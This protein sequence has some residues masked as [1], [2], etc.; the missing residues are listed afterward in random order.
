MEDITEQFNLPKYTKGKSFAD[1]SSMIMDKF[2]ER[3][4]PESKRTMTEMLDRLRQAQEFVKEQNKTPEERQQEQ[5]QMEQQAQM[6]AKQS[7]QQVDPQM[8]QQVLQEQPQQTQFA[9]G[10]LMNYISKNKSNQ[11]D[12]GGVIS[13]GNKFG[14]FMKG[15]AGGIASAGAGAMNMIGDLSGEGVSTNAGTAGLT[16]AAK[17]AMAGMAL[18]PVG[19][20]IGGVL[21]G[22]AGLIGS[23][24]AK[25]EMI[26]NERNE[27]QLNRN[28][29]LNTFAEGG[30]LN[31]DPT[32]PQNPSDLIKS[33]KTNQEGLDYKNPYPNRTN[34]FH[35]FDD[36]QK[37]LKNRSFGISPVTPNYGSKLPFGD[38]TGGTSPI[39]DEIKLKKALLTRPVVTNTKEDYNEQINNAV[40][41]SFAKGGKITDTNQYALG[42]WLKRAGKN[43]GA[44]ATKTGQFLNENK[45]DILRYTPTAINAFQL[46]KLPKA[47]VE[48]LNRLDNRFKPNYVDEAALQNISREN[49]N[50]SNQALTG[51]SG[52]STSALRSNILGAGLNRNKALSSAYLKADDINRGQDN[53]AQQFNAGIDK[54]NLQQ[55]NSEKDI[56][57]RNR[58]AR[59]NE[60]SKL[61]S[62]IGTDIGSIGK[63]EKYKDIIEKISG[64]DKDGKLVAAKKAKR[65]A[66]EKDRAIK[67]NTKKVMKSV[68]KSPIKAIQRNDF[69]LYNGLKTYNV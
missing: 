64:Y 63:E 5:M 32:Y 48:S 69:N 41:N 59:D 57:A 17:G 54:V 66:A 19:A 58:A 51:A 4:D 6:Q 34:R 29:S 10:G 9:E 25:R 35:K 43:V 39:K 33:F 42:D 24:K 15:N 21:G 36:Y 38:G 3:K 65:E 67:K 56:N 61:L 13:D 46:A 62:G 60:K 31:P 20:A 37:R 45:G 68:K 16:G 8:Q 40:N 49:Y 14:K 27:T 18:G 26:E 23:G 52:G 7:Q 1:A 50:M 47:E 28:Q 30:Q 22:A 12:E 44:A 11:F 55:S 53:T 2:K